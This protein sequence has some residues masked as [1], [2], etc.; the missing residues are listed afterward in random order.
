VNISAE[1]W[2]VR[3]EE[4]NARPTIF[5]AGWSALYREVLANPCIC[6]G[7]IRLAGV[8]AHERTHLDHGG[9]EVRAYAA[10]LNTLA[11][12]QAP[13][14]Y[15]ANVRRALQTVMRQQQARR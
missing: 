7:T 15:Q 5:I 8:L 4:G 9:D 12:L 11:S 1:G 2:V 10:Q 13:D 3:H 14:I 6:H